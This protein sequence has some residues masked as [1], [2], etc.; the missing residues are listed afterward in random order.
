MFGQFLPRFDEFI[1]EV[2]AHV[3]LFKLTGA[4]YII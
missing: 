1:Y 4:L 3:V 2:N